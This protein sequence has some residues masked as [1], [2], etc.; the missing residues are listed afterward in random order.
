[1]E[2]EAQ[3]T[4]KACGNWTEIDFSKKIETPKFKK[5]FRSYL[6][7]HLGRGITDI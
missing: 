2:L 3:K 1:M 4:N 6:R 7:S 5:T